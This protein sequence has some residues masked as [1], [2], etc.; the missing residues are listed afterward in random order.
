MLITSL[1]VENYKSL[2]SIFLD[3]TGLTVLVGANGSGKTNLADSIDFVSE[4]YRHGLELAV[5]RRGGYENIAHHKRRR[6]KRSVGIDVTAIYDWEPPGSKNKETHHKIKTRHKF[7]FVTKG[8]SI[9]AEF[10]IVQE[11]VEVYIYLDDEWKSL[12]QVERQ[13]TKVKFKK[14]AKDVLKK[15]MPRISQSLREMYMGFWNL[16]SLVEERR[17]LSNTELVVTAVG[18]LRGVLRGLVDGM[19][20]IKV[21]QI[22]PTMSREFGVP[23]PSPELART[24]AN[25]PAVVDLLQKKYPESWEQ[26]LQIMTKVL[27]GLEGIEVGYNT[28]RTLGL[29]FRE[30]ETGRPWNVNEIS[31]GTIQTLAI[32]VAIF[33]PRSSALVIEE[34]ENSV[35][36]WVIRNIL[37]AC[38]L[39]AT[40]KQILITTHSPIVVNYVN[41]E[42]VWIIWRADGESKIARITE[43]DP[44]FMDLWQSG[45]VATFEFLDSG[46]IVEAIP[47]S[48]EIDYDQ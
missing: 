2:R 23:T 11:Q 3:P 22:S 42:Q 30:K 46:A 45:K 1:K 17:A 16:N 32:L 6:S 39:A 48:P 7:A 33:D 28:S 27:P 20:S 14:G 9:R 35:H 19:S 43:L 4:I 13:D 26:I 38:N 37:S 25:L 18:R 12:L 44:G 47:P 34:P 8:S 5:A 36:P 15:A 40:S 29:F 24:G 10:Y 31:D 41:P 21:F